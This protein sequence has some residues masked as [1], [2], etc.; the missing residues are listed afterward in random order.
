MD[1]SSQSPATALEQLLDAVKSK[2]RRAFEAFYDATV[3]KVYSL[4]VCITRQYDMAEEVVSDVYLQVWRDAG[5][6]EAGRGSVMAWLTMLCRS[7]ALDAMRRRRSD[8]THA[9]ISDVAVTTAGEPEHPQELLIAVEQGSAVHHA[10]SKLD[11]Q[12]RQLLALAFFR[13]YSHSELATI[14]GLPLGTVK[15]QLRRTLIQLKDMLSA[16]E[17]SSGDAQ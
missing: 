9:A 7:R 4:A 8:A 14:T 6:F 15:T 10:L 3:H 16:A 13:G 17:V 12:Q 11:E 2:E 1:A 5:R